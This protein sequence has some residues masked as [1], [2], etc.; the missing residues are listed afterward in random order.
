MAGHGP[1]AD[2]DTCK[3]QQDDEAQCVT[4]VESEGGVIRVTIEEG[5]GGTISVMI[6]E[7]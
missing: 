7:E 6:E 3:Q 5:E 2:L 4:I 1:A